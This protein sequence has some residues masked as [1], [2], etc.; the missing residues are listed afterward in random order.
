M[1]TNGPL[2][3]GGGELE[4]GGQVCPPRSLCS[5]QAASPPRHPLPTPLPSRERGGR[6]PLR[7]PARPLRA[8][9]AVGL[10]LASLPITLMTP[11]RALAYRK[12]R[13]IWSP[14]LLWRPEGLDQRSLLERGR[15]PR[16]GRG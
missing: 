5:G 1:G 11:P 9:V 8:L 4:R 10:V 13:P 12:R 2:P 15:R 7:L 16:T 3:P 6:L 14:G